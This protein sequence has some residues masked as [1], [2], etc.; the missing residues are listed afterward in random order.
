VVYAGKHER[1]D[2]LYQHAGLLLYPPL[3]KKLW[4]LFYMAVRWALP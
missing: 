4:L 2:S 1:T 3:N